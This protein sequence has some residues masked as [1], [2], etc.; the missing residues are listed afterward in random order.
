MEAKR[1]PDGSYVGRTGPNCEFAECPMSN[2]FIKVISPNG[3]E[4]WTVRERY[5]IL[6]AAVG[7]DYVDIGYKIMDPGTEIVWIYKA[8]LAPVGEH[9]WLIP[10]REIFTKPEFKQGDF[11]III[12]ERLNEPDT[13]HR[14]SDLSDNSFTI[15]QSS[16]VISWDTYRNA[17]YGYELQY[18][19]F[20]TI[21]YYPDP[22]TPSLKDEIGLT[23]MYIRDVVSESQ[24]DSRKNDC[25]EHVSENKFHCEFMTTT[26]NIPVVINWLDG[27]WGDYDGKAFIA[28]PN[29]DNY[30]ILDLIDGQNAEYK[31][32]FYQMLSTF[33]FLE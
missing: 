1:C 17:E 23:A 2:K 16:D 22:N 8:A 9:L 28:I 7:I 27:V 29:Q 21:N 20:W 33:R 13:D 26:E 18:P 12:R 15:T 14:I 4:K 3:G 31:S 24:L 6:W 19:H 11:K 5:N 25:I 10:A 30:V 32:I